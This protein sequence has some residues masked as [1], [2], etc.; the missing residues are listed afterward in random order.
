MGTMP[1]F[2]AGFPEGERLLI[3]GAPAD[4][5][6]ETGVAVEASGKIFA[7]L[8]L[9][10]GIL[11]RIPESTEYSQGKEFV[12]SYFRCKCDLNLHVSEHYTFPRLGKVVPVR[13]NAIAWY[14][15]RRV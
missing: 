1:R 3:G 11:I 10:R 14:Q 7:I 12:L 5:G 9:I 15:S 8:S 2:G 13:V 6:G 4:T